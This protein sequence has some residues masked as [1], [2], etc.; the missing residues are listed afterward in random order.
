M[1]EVHGFLAGHP[2]ALTAATGVVCLLAGILTGTLMLRSRLDDGRTV[3]RRRLVTAMDHM[4]QGVVLFDSDNRLL[5]CNDQY[6]RMY[7]LSRE[8]IQ[9][10]CTLQEIMRYRLQN[11]SFDR[12]PET[13]AKELLTALAAGQTI[14]R[15]VEHEDG[16]A[17]SVIN[18]KLANGDW[19]GTHEDISVRRRAERELEHTRGFLDL[20]INSVPSTIV[21]KELPE[22]RYV[23][24]NKSG[25][26]YFGMPREQMIGK[27]A[28]Q[29]FARET[30][31][32]IT[33]ADQEVVCSGQ[34][35]RQDAKPVLHRGGRDRIVTSVRLPVLGANGE[36]Q[37]VLGVIDDITERKQAES[38]IAHMAH[39]DNLTDLP[40]RVAFG[41]ELARTISQAKE[42]NRQFAVLCLDLDHFKEVN[43]IFGH[44]VGDALLTEVSR[45]LSA[46]TEGAFVARLGGDEFAVLLAE[47][48][49]PK[50]AEVLAERLAAAITGN[51]DIHHH[52]LRVGLSVG[53]AVFPHDGTDE[54]SLLANA[55]AALYRAKA[56]GR[57]TVRFFDSATDERLRE[58]RALQVE[59]RTALARNELS[60]FYQPQAATEG[61]I[62]G[63]EALVRWRHPTRGFVPPGVFIP[64]A[65][66]SGYIIELGEW[67]LREACREAASWPNP[68]KIAV[69][70][71]PIQFRHGDLAHLVQGILVETGLSPARL[72][73]EITES[74]LI[75]DS[76]RALS[77]LRR[78]KAMGIHIAMDDF[79]TGYSSL[80]YL[81]AF[82]FD[83]IK[84]DQAFISNLERNEQSAAIVK[85]VIGLAHG[86]R[87]PVT[88]EGVETADQLEILKAEAC[89]EVQGYLIG[90]P[91]PIGHYAELIGRATLPRQASA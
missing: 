85:A 60:L 81:Q 32:A 68:L 4:T 46:A 75:N 25:E 49:Q 43:D 11:G 5:V 57:G 45:R 71:S 61:P 12:D 40:N 78:L 24:V 3:R 9:P 48:T 6:I 1:F 16:R 26:Q 18:K 66:E 76:S 14:A 33:A 51:I 72:E 69:N 50:S 84:I 70:F 30:A 15:I 38:R 64:L 10:G 82:P 28:A 20:I 87:V 62:V 80:S 56:D 44:S 22:L 53:I 91:Q 39:H 36:P 7:G 90:R 47:G 83:K 35:L 67:I 19:I 37:Y 8:E 52:P 13:Y 23:L 42:F 55:D 79:G 59:L 74:V 17:I 77:V 31:A 88:A 65:E 21:V 86:L 29:L 73:I 63:F 27:T 34:P 41:Q 54:K 2:L 89:N 58:R